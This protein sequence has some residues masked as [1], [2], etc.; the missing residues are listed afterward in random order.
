[1]VTNANAGLAYSST[2]ATNASDPNGNA[3]TFAKVSGPAWLSVVSNGS[4]GG[5][6]YSVDVGTNVFVV[7]VTDPYGMSNTA[8]MN[9]PVI[10]APP[11]VMTTVVQ[12]GQLQVNWNGGI[13]PYQVQMTTN[14]GD[15]DWQVVGT[16][17]LGN[18]LSVPLTNAAAFY[19]LSGQ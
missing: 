9:L 7:S 15:P 13:A 10:A 11:I 18:T 8:T 1:M 14:L 16:S 12:G 4:L 2:L 5:T 17:V 3:I 19:R 6:P